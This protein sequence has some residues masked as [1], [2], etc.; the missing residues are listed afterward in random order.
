MNLIFCSM[1]IMNVYE[2]VFYL[3]NSVIMDDITSLFNFYLC[4][5]ISNK[6]SLLHI[7]YIDGINCSVN[8]TK[9]CRGY[10]L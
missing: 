8:N 1:K 9:Q 4:Y 10:V 3:E 2:Y 5:R 6:R 7:L